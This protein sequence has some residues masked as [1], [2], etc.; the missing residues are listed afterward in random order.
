LLIFLPAK[1]EPAMTRRMRLVTFAVLAIGSVVVGASLYTSGR[2][3]A[4]TVV[5]LLVVATLGAALGR[6][7]HWALGPR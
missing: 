7:L 4:A 3:T 5:G 6:F 1:K 2:L